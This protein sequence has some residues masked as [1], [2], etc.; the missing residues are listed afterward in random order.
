MRASTGCWV[1]GKDSF[2]CEGELR[3]LEARSSDEGGGAQVQ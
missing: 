2:D 3:V 1:S